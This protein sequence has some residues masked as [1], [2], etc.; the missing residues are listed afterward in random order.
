MPSQIDR[1][2]AKE[3]LEGIFNPGDFC[4]IDEKG[5]PLT[6]SLLATGTDELDNYLCAREG[7]AKSGSGYQWT[8]TGLGLLGHMWTKTKKLRSH[9]ERRD[10][11]QNIWDKHMHGRN[12]Q[13]HLKLDIPPTCP[14]CEIAVD[15]KAHYALRCTHPYFSCAREG[16]ERQILERIWKLPP[17]VGK[18]TIQAL[19]QW[20][21]YPEENSCSEKEEMARM[22]LI[23][24][25]PLKESL[26]IGDDTQRIGKK[27]RPGLLE[28]LMDLWLTTGTYLHQLWKLCGSI[29]A[30]PRE[31]Q[32]TMRTHAAFPLDVQGLIRPYYLRSQHRSQAHW[33][34][35]LAK[36]CKYHRYL[37]P[38]VDP[39][40]VEMVAPTVKQTTPSR[41][42]PEWTRWL[43]RHSAFGKPP[44][45]PKAPTVK[46]R[47]NRKSRKKKTNGQDA[48]L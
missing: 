41:W 12:Q 2:S 19:W 10:Q 37:A 16:F 11:V 48:S 4:W 3:I 28:C 35:S 8:D 45:H 9:A 31:V 24:G 46:K 1:V 33:L 40:E 5:F 39:E 43:T 38:I 42:D 27:E 21:F 7:Y 20:V 26:K 14:L 30:A 47:R 23:L 25:R 29:I 36:F 44:R 13:K 6:A 32:R 34:S 18:T 17:G 15:S 22:G